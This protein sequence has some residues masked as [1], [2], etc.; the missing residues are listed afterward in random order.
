MKENIENRSLN[1]IQALI[2]TERDCDPSIGEYS[3]IITG[4]VGSLDLSSDGGVDDITLIKD[5]IENNV[6]FLALPAEGFTDVLLRESGEWEGES[7]H[8]Y[9]EVERIVMNSA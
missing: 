4:F 7:W 9:Y 3:L 1:Y 5:A 2:Y 8:K 6:D